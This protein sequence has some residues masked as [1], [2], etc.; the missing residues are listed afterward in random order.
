MALASDTTHAL[1]LHRLDLAIGRIPIP[2]ILAPHGLRLTLDLSTPTP[3]LRARARQLTV[4]GLD[5][6]ALTLD[7]PL[8][9]PRLECRDGRLALR[10]GDG[11]QLEFMLAFRRTE[12][13]LNVRLTAPTA[14]DD[15][16][17]LELLAADGGAWTLRLAATDATRGPLAALLRAVGATRFAGRWPAAVTGRIG[18]KAQAEGRGT[19]ID[20]VETAVTLEE[21]GFDAIDAALQAAL[22]GRLLARRRDDTWWF[23]F[24]TR[25]EAGL[26]YLVPGWY[27]GGG[28]PGLLLDA[29]RDGALDL[30]AR[31]SW[32]P[33]A[34]HWRIDS[35]RLA[36]GDWLRMQASLDSLEGQWRQFGLTLEPAPF[37]AL[38][39]GWLQPFLADGPLD[40]L[41]GD[42]RVAL[43]LAHGEA[44][45]SLR[46]ELFGLTLADSRGRFTLAGLNGRIAAGPRHA[47]EVHTL[48]V[49]G[50]RLHGLPL[51]RARL[52]LV[53][54]RAG[55]RL[56]DEVEFPLLDGRLVLEEMELGR[57]ERPADAAVGPA[58]AP[59]P[60]TLR[61]S[62]V[63]TPV[64]L[65]AL[66][67]ALDLPRAAGHFSGVLPEVVASAAGFHLGGDLLLRLFDGRIVARGLRVTDP[68]GTLPEL[69]TDLD[70]TG[71]DLGLLTHEGHFGRISGRLGGHV[72]GLRMQA[73]QPVAMDLHLGTPADNDRP[74]RIS[75]RA[76]DSITA[77]S[78]AGAGLLSRGFMRLFDE[79]SY[80]RLGV[81]CR[82]VDGMCH[83]SGV[84]R[85][86]DGSV[87]LVSRGGLLPPWIEVRAE[88]RQVAWQTLVEV[89][90]RI[91]RGEL[92]IGNDR[93]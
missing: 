74:R 89:Y 5:L 81:G 16:Q 22:H 47:G 21:L 34:A 61:L 43:R 1:P 12:A 59:A 6:H 82:L 50:L 26:L 17:S 41:E 38:Y 20:R 55:F 58:S 36:Q 10:L 52:P 11:P 44:E 92:E 29:G 84:G 66:C 62:G 88:R 35:L 14:A 53:T 63:L 2:G 40:T 57:A 19:A 83:L 37:D 73:W 30:S 3:T 67:D 42:G 60:L 46:L 70:L 9:L 13:G 68:F 79:Y 51:G 93:P 48:T 8:L 15:G 4:H 86:A 87:V 64:S 77:L 31:G 71:L 45:S 69:A 33:R 24:E 28:L 27:I 54:T 72:H 39:R 23:Q 65:P 85:G 76:V 78:G 7:C 49:E 18:L 56:R 91:A 80:G 75:Q 90:R 32:R 25:H